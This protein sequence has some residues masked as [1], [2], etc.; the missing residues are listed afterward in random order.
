MA[1][2]TF[3]C[4]N[5]SLSTTTWHKATNSPGTERWSIS[6]RFHGLA[7]SRAK[8][9][10][11]YSWASCKLMAFLQMLAYSVQKWKGRKKKIPCESCLAFS[12]C[13][14]SFIQQTFTG[15]SNIPVPVL[16]ID[17]SPIGAPLVEHEFLGL[18][19]VC[20][21]CNTA[22]C[23]EQAI[24]NLQELTTHHIWEALLASLTNHRLGFHTHT[25]PFDSPGTSSI[26]HRLFKALLEISV[27][28]FTPLE[29]NL[30]VL[31]TGLSICL[32]RAGKIPQHM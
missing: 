31:V 11:T 2:S 19:D 18:Q 8:L 30:F 13:T 20:T 15:T 24:D 25:Y 14:C 6:P 27:Y 16:G 9:Q 32:T 29:Y 26:H 12:M 1:L 28:L 22:S 21:E 5:S 17:N 10:T 4:I 7:S 3:T 23:N